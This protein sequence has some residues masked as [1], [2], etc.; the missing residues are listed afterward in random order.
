MM[1]EVSQSCQELQG[2]NAK[3]VLFKSSP[4]YFGQDVGAWNI[5][6]NVTVKES[7]VRVLDLEV[8]YSLSV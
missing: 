2:L 4:C 3:T 5:M 6:R 1:T 7:V 8:K